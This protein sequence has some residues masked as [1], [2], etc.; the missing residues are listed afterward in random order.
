MDLEA[1]LDRIRYDGKCE[2]TVETLTQLHK[3]HMYSVPFENLD[4][5]LGRPIVL[6]LPSLFEKVV[7]RRRGGFCYELNALFGWLLQE[8]GFQLEMLSGRV[9][10]E[11]VPGP[12][13]DHMLLLVDVG[14]KLVVDVGFGDSFIE[15]IP[16]G[17]EAQVQNGRLYRLVA[18]GEA[19]ELQQRAPESDWTPQYAF[20]LKSRQLDDFHAMCYYQQTATDSVFTRKSVCSLATH[21]GRITLSNG[22]LII[23]SEGGRQERV[24]ASV[25]EYQALLRECFGIELGDESDAEILLNPTTPPNQRIGRVSGKTDPT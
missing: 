25:E 7:R 19:W 15:P 9:Y 3:A 22:R 16:L 2:P 13:F 5:T 20:S 4:I 21:D 17:P 6:S 11:G 14:Q 8:M 18:R 1:Y 10:D 12:E 24:V 23:T